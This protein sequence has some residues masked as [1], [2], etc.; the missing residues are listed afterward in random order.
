MPMRLHLVLSALIVVAVGVPARA[1]D[2]TDRSVDST[3]AVPEARLKLAT[4]ACMAR[5]SNTVEFRAKQRQLEEAEA[6][7]KAM[8]EARDAQLADASTAWIRAKS[9]VEG[10]K[11]EALTDDAAV[12]SAK[13]ALADAR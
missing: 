6:H 2:R 1:G 3:V 12:Q 13:R 8:R 5:L 10:M 4:D 7:V 9:D 11:A